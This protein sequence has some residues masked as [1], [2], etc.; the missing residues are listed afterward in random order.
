MISPFF[1]GSAIFLKL[2]GGCALI[3]GQILFISPLYSQCN[4]G[5]CSPSLPVFVPPTAAQDIVSEFRRSSTS[6]LL[7]Q[8]TPQPMFRQPNPFQGSSQPAQA[9]VRTW[10]NGDGQWR[11]LSNGSACLVSSS[12]KSSPAASPCTDTF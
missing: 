4:Q 10:S 9:S 1:P 8:E 7:P 2:L 12:S 3:S 11:N 5:S 6:F